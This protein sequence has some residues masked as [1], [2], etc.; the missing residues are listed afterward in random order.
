[1]LF[2]L[3]WKINKCRSI[4]FSAVNNTAVDERVILLN[5]SSVAK[6]CVEPTKL[7]KFISLPSV[8]FTSYC[9]SCD[10]N[11]LTTLHRCII[12]NSRFKTMNITE[13]PCKICSLNPIQKYDI[14]NYSR[15]YICKCQRNK[16]LSLIKSLSCSVAQKSCD[17]SIDGQQQKDIRTTASGI[18]NIS[19]SPSS[20]YM[21]TVKSLVP[22]TTWTC[23]QCTLLNSANY[24]V[25]EAC[26]SPYSPDL[27]S[28]I[29]PS[30]IIKVMFK[31]M[32]CFRWSCFI[33]LS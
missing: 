32:F 19:Y 1:M 21:W 27:N 26:E 25:C 12:C 10:I 22:S 24:T 7:K 2:I 6:K 4:F 30:V 8:L 17:S 3:S 9:E 13:S 29:K 33:L 28:N 11:F 15:P 14:L 5:T 31:S 20:N 16:S 18:N 23:K